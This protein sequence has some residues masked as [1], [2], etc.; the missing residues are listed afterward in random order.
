MRS[1]RG[2]LQADFCFIAAQRADIQDATPL[3]FARAI[4][5]QC[6]LSAPADAPLQENERS[7]GVDGQSFR[8]FIKR[9]SIE[10]V[11]A[12]VNGDLHDNALAATAR[13]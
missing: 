12:Y 8:F 6:D 10:I 2:E 1:R 4:V 13:E 5:L 3:L 9:T 7:V 11:S